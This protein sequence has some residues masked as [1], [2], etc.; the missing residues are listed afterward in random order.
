MEIFLFIIVILVVFFVVKDFFIPFTKEMFI[1]NDLAELDRSQGLNPEYEKNQ[2]IH[3]RKQETEAEEGKKR[4]MENEKNS[5]VEQKVY[6]KYHR[7]W[8]ERKNISLPLIV[9][10]EHKER[11]LK[12]NNNVYWFKCDNEHSYESKIKDYFENEGKCP[13]CVKNSLYDN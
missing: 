3:Y 9:F 7:Q 4:D 11:I 8:D 2:R 10:P 12:Y 6:Y 13:I 1:E 5:S